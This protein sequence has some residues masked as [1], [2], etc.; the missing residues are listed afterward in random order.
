ML[1]FPEAWGIAPEAAKRPTSHP[2]LYADKARFKAL[3]KSRDGV[4]SEL[5]TIVLEEADKAVVE[6]ESLRTD[7]TPSLGIVRSAQGRLL[8][9]SAAY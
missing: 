1:S 4:V 3:S 5:R 8:N 6:M 9:L 2:Y 7:I